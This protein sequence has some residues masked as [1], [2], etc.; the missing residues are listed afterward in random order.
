M[1]IDDHN[2]Y[3]RKIGLI[4]FTH[5]T[6]ILTHTIYFDLVFLTQITIALCICALYQIGYS[7]LIKKVFFPHERT[8]QNQ[9][10][11]KFAKTALP[12]SCE[13]MG[14]FCKFW[15]VLIF[16]STFYKKQSLAPLHSLKQFHSEKFLIDL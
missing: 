15:D 3:L 6:C 5:T 11:P 4:Y 12:Y 9:V 16:S 8:L 1:R 13:L 2:Y 14:R 7:I 10:I